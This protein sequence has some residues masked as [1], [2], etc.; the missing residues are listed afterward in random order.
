[1]VYLSGAGAGKR[2]LNGCGCTC[3]SSYS[4]LSRKNVHKYMYEI[5]KFVAVMFLYCWFSIIYSQQA[6]IT[7]ISSVHTRHYPCPPP[8]NTSVQNDA[9]TPVFTGREHGRRKMTPVFMGRVGHQCIQHG[10][11]ILT[12]GVIF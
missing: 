10:C 12:P 1:M 11:H 4:A 6:R 7:Y 5:S 9:R 3:S 2:P 8:V